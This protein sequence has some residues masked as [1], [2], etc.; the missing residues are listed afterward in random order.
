VRSLISS[1]Y[2]HF[3]NGSC[4]ISINILSQLSSSGSASCP[5]S[6]KLI[7]GEHFA[8]RWQCKRLDAILTALLQRTDRRPCEWASRVIE[9]H[10]Y[11]IA[12]RSSA[13]ANPR[14]CSTFPE[15]AETGN[16]NSGAWSMPFPG[17]V[18]HGATNFTPMI[19]Y[20]AAHQKLRYVEISTRFCSAA[21][22][23]TTYARL[24]H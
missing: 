7:A 16:G 10:L 17:L 18:R 6:R 5:D 15:V 20:T 23:C 11:V 9:S 3:S 4:C 21:P 22:S 24:Q 2:V 13:P 1:S 12:L 19:Y 8:C 14:R